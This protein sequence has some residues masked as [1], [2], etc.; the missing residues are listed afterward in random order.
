MAT[1]TSPLNTRANEI[2]VEPIIIPLPETVKGVANPVIS[3]GGTWK[4]NAAPPVEFWSTKIDP[5]SWSDAVVPGYTLTQGFAIAPDHE[6]AYRTRIHIPADYQGQTILLRFDGVAGYARVWVEDTYV[7]DHYGGFTSWYCDITERVSPSED[8][9]L[10]VGVTDKPKEIS[11]FNLGG[12]IRD[13]TL[14]AVPPDHVTRFRV[15]TDLDGD[16]RDATLK[17]TAVMAFGRN[18][19]AEIQLSLQDPQGDALDIAPGA[20]ELSA[21]HPQATVAIPVAAP[22]K[23]DAEHPNLY[24]L[25]ARVVIQGSTVETILKKA[26][27]CGEKLLA[28]IQNKK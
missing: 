8:A 9:W 20:I 6:Y 19:G 5:A 24:A 11:V 2:C 3:L 18:A 21:D 15:E 23:W 25:T 22:Q 7:R 10:T 16:Y 4:L 13:V 1:K 17:V 12:I 14:L 26:R 28:A 27:G